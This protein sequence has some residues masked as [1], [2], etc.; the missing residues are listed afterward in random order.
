M[1]DGKPSCPCGA[2]AT[3]PRAR[4]VFCRTCDRA[5][6]RFKSLNRQKKRR[7]E[8]WRKRQAYDRR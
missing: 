2:N 8:R 3:S 4:P 7:A 6:K 5:N 1:T